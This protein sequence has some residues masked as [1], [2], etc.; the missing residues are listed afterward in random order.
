MS[1]CRCSGELLGS[2]MLLTG[3]PAGVDGNALSTS[4]VAKFGSFPSGNRDKGDK[5]AMDEVLFSEEFINAMDWKFKDMSLDEPKPSLK[6]TDE[7]ERLQA[8]AFIWERLG[9]A[10]D[11][12][13]QCIEPLKLHP[14]DCDLLFPYIPQPLTYSFDNY[15]W[16]ESQTSSSPWMDE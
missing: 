12:V 11:R 13:G 10:I 14:P 7:L 6:V 16:T 4:L 15:P 8:E 2:P 5:L 1:A 3:C 9:N